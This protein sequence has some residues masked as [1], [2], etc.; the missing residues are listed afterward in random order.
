MT[1]V[2]QASQVRQNWSN[3][4]NT[5]YKENSKVIIEKSGIPV[6]A[7]ISVED[8]KRFTQL[9]EQ[10]KERFKTLDSIREAF[11]DVPDEEVE[12]EIKKALNEVRTE[13]RSENSDK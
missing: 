13:M 7:V 12:Q 11:K 2:M 10:R 4:L 5:I 6:A 8:L 9:D 3:I 1:K